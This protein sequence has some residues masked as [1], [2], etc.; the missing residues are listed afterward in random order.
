[1]SI[2]RVPLIVFDY[3]AFEPE[4]DLHSKRLKRPQQS[5]LLQTIDSEVN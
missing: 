1:M 3:L 5:L 2:F 4:F